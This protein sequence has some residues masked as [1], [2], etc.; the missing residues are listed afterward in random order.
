[1]LPIVN[2]Y[3]L[4]RGDGQV[5]STLQF[6]VKSAVVMPKG[7]QGY[8]ICKCIRHRS[9][10]GKGQFRELNADLVQLESG[11]KWRKEVGGEA[12]EVT[13]RAGSQGHCL[14]CEGP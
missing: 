12:G 6:A 5:N 11:C 9:K 13:R 8:S 3:S 2:S 10:R 1:M 14:R 7:Q 4:V